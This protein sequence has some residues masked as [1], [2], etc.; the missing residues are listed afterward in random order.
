MFSGDVLSFSKTS[1][2]RAFHP[3]IPAIY[4]K[5]PHFT[6]TILPSLNSIHHCLP[7]GAA[8]FLLFSSSTSCFQLLLSLVPMEIPLSR[9]QSY[10]LDQSQSDCYFSA[11]G[12]SGSSYFS[13][14]GFV[15][16][17]GLRSKVR[18]WTSHFS[19]I[20]CCSTES[21]IRRPKSS[22]IPYHEK[23][24]PVLEDTQMRKPSFV[25]LCSEIEKLV[26]CNRYR[27]A[28]ELFEI[29]ELEGGGRYVGASTYDALVSAC[30][31]LRYIR[32]VKKV[33]NLMIS[34]G[35][36]LDLY[37]MNRMLFMHVR[38]GLMRDAWK[39]FDDMPERDEVSWTMMIGG[40]VDSGNNDEAF[41]L[42]L[43]M[44]EE[45]N[46]G[47]PH[48]FV[49]MIK[50]AAGLGLIQVGRQIHSCALKME[51]GDDTF[52][53]CALI[54][55]YSK[56]GSIDDAY[57][58]FDQMPK[59]TTVAWNSIISG[60][61]LH[62]Y[63]EEALNLF[64]EMRNI[65]AK[66]DHFTIS[67]VIRICTRLA[68]FEH[69][70][71][72]H[73]ALVRHG[74]GT[75]LV[76]NSALVD[77]YSKWGRMEDARHVF[78]TMHQKN[79]ISWNALI[80][81][82]GNH[83][84]GEEALEMF[85]QMLRERMVPNHVTFLAVLSACSYSGLSERGWEIF[86][87]MSKDHKIK[88]RPMHYACMIELL[89][90]EGLLDEALALIRLAPFQPTAN[91]WAA[92]LTACRMHENFILGKL[93]AEKLYGMEPE[94]MCNYVVLLNIYNTTGRLKEAA[95]VLQT[96]KRK[97]LR[98]LHACTWI[99][100]K[101]RQNVFLSGDK[102]HPQTEEIYQK[103]DNLMEEISRYGYTVEDDE[104]L[105]PDVDEE[106]Q[107]VLKYHSEKLAIA[108]GLINTPNW[109][110]L[111]I[112][113]GHRICRDCHTAIKL[114][115]LVTGREIVVRDASRFHHFRNGSCSCG[116]YW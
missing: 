98:M 87:S 12:S 36:E 90:R 99:E 106:E 4:R 13:G 49:T 81:G 92:L 16:G 46:D 114:I 11:L 91:M 3:Y 30:V 54:D 31:G 9:Y 115:A 72:A 80:A 1:L 10:T 29:L 75:D 40:L 41:R 105:L 17:C 51:V 45:F 107:R 60:Y 77:F 43:C 28:I 7:P 19:L 62:G 2:L 67:T 102:S 93:A 113:Q 15:F 76:A 95:G 55:M 88:P 108:F 74:F 104:A 112:M 94:K 64:Y 58:V 111:Q 20:C 44:W 82:Y 100:V 61:A 42:F 32:G 96:L 18:N 48:T 68:S 89:G 71:Q 79:I 38:C 5:E 35:F 22:R 103:V 97:G 23:V 6:S 37:M 73:A 86:Q 110:P 26:L 34:S 69:A 109:M 57:C 56:C 39:L 83:G 116:D 59:K 63:S 25:G 52:V 101:R 47:S 84:Q 14:K 70:K 50:A 8:L 21:G 53:S 24:E 65:G 66:L 27:D 33:F 78:D 85:E